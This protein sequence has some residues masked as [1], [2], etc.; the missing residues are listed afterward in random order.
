MMGFGD[1]EFWGYELEDRVSSTEPGGIL[2]TINL[3]DTIDIG[4]LR[5]SGSRSTT[6]HVLTID[7]LGIDIELEP[8]ARHGTLVITPDKAGTFNVYCR[9][10][11]DAHGKTVLVVKG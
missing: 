3:G 5:V 6:P 1:N 11:P 9:L 7:E 8:G 4:T 2:M 10:H